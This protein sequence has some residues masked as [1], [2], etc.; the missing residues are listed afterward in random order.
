MSRRAQLRSLVEGALAAAPALALLWAVST[1]DPYV[2]FPPLALADR[3]IRITPGSLA[4]WAIDHLHHAAQPLLGGGVTVAFLVVAAV[5]A[6]GVRGGGRFGAAGAG[7]VAPA[8]SG[9]SAFLSPTP[10]RAAPP[11]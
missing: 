7:V 8:M 4:T 3:I 1:A 9:P 5:L 6:V 2:P 10:L 11:N